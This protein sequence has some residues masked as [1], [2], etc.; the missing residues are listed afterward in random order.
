MEHAALEKLVLFAGQELSRILLVPKEID[1]SLLLLLIYLYCYFDSPMLF[2]NL[3][4]QLTK[5][6]RIGFDL[7]PIFWFK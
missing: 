1:W 7:A 4:G 2:L 6:Y 3:Q 5:A